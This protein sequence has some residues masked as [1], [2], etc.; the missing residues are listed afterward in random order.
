MDR[1]EALKELERLISQGLWPA[2]TSAEDIGFLEGP[3]ILV[4]YEAFGGSLNAALEV[5]EAAI[6]DEGWRVDWIAKYP[7]MMPGSSGYPYCAKVG[8]GEQHKGHAN[9][10][11]RA[12]LLAIIRALISQ[13]EAQNNG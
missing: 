12:W 4:W 9:N 2:D 6:P 11:A 1:L 10:P 5:H 8:W 13:Q 3:G 7:G